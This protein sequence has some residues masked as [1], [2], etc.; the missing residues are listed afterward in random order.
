MTPGPPLRRETVESRG[1]SRGRWG[2][3]SVSATTPVFRI[4]K[5][6]GLL[7]SGGNKPGGLLPPGVVFFLQPAARPPARPPAGSPGS[8]G[9]PPGLPP[10][11]V[12]SFLQP[13]ARP[14]PARWAGSPGSRGSP[15]GLL[16]PG[17]VSF[18]QPAARP[19]P[20]RWA[21]SP[22][23]RGSPP[24]HPLV[25]PWRG[26]GRFRRR[27]HSR[28]CPRAGSARSG[29]RR[30][31]GAVRRA[32]GWGRDSSRRPRGGGARPARCR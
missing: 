25:T 26:R 16:P 6:E 2:C 32:P 12:V 11:G 7:P 24:G 31:R 29:S 4:I 13:A 20:A 14:L 21:G 23:S 28:T 9:S 17:V 10:P 15:P 30:L 18:L 8:R 22:G 19:L 1:R 5:P 27:R 3:F